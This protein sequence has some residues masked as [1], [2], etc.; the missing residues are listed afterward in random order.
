MT[1]AT[2]NGVEANDQVGQHSER[3][4]GLAHAEF[5][6]NRPAGGG[7][8]DRDGVDAVCADRVRHDGDVADFGQ[9][10]GPQQLVGGSGGQLRGGQSGSGRR[11]PRHGEGLSDM[12]CGD[13]AGERLHEPARAVVRALYR[14]ECGNERGE[15]EES[16][17]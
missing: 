6:R 16:A 14:A 3:R 8:A 12:M 11:C 7:G 10:V 2:P 9:D 17:S 5:C 4:P 15:E 13:G 1:R